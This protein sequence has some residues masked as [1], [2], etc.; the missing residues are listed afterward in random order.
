MQYRIIARINASHYL[1]NSDI[2]HV[3]DIGC[4]FNGCRKLVELKTDNVK[5]LK[6]LHFVSVFEGCNALKNIDKDFLNL[7]L[8]S[9]SLQIIWI[10]I[11]NGYPYF[12]LVIYSNF[13]T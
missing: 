5:I 11:I 13:N 1:S 10:D 2:S 9:T 4:A 8:E 12:Y 7:E 6:L 3:K